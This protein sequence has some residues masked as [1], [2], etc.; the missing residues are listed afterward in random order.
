MNLAIQ[1]RQKAALYDV[2]EGDDQAVR[3]AV[4]RAQLEMGRS[5]PIESRLE[6]L[7]KAEANGSQEAKRE[8]KSLE[9]R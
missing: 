3:A 8:V 6:W 4:A 5:G 7:R 9:T 1:L 2:K